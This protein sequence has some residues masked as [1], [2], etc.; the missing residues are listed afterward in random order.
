[1][2]NWLISC[3]FFFW[4]LDSC[5]RKLLVLDLVMVL[6]WVMVLVWFMLMLL[7]LMVM[8]WVV[9]LKL[10]CMCSLLLFFS[11]VGWVRVLKCSLLVVLVVLEISLCRKIFLLE[12]SEWIISCS[13]CL[14]LVW[15]LR[16]L[17]WVVLVI[18]RVLCVM[19]C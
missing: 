12:Y 14:I 19:L 1:M 6:R 16:V 15:K 7:F 17:V 10:M 4:L 2:L 11:S 3:E 13:S 18:D 8:V 5:C 9:V